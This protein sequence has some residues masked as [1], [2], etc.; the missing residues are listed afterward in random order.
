MFIIIIV[1]YLLYT[2]IDR[3]MGD[4]SKPK[5]TI[6]LEEYNTLID[7]SSSNDPYKKLLG[8]I[9]TT[10]NLQNNNSSVFYVKP[11]VELKDLV[12]LCAKNN[13]EVHFNRKGDQLEVIGVDYKNR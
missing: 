11:L 3:K 7:G 4:Y 5:V 9:A 12:E 10:L 13:L 2:K 8:L 1:I 6:D